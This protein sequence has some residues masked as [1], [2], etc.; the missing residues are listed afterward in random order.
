MIEIGNVSYHLKCLLDY[1]LLQYYI[2]SFTNSIYITNH[3][4]F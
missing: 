2:E 1:I 3:N 4:I